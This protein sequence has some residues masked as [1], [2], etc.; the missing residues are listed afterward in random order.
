MRLLV[1]LTLLGLTAAQVSFESAT[2]LSE[3][4]LSDFLNKNSDKVPV[5][6][7]EGVTSAT[8]EQL[9]KL[10]D[11]VVPFRIKGNSDSSASILVY[12][13]GGEARAGE[14]KPF[15]EA[16]LV[17]TDVADFLLARMQ[18]K[19]IQIDNRSLQHY[20]GQYVVREKKKVFVLFEAPGKKSMA[21]RALCHQKEFEDA[22]FMIWS[23]DIEVLK[24][25]M[26]VNKLPSVIYFFMP[27]DQP[28]EDD[29]A[30]KGQGVGVRPMNAPVTFRNLNLF[31][32]IIL[33][34]KV[35]EAQKANQEKTE[36]RL[37]DT[38]V[39]IGDGKSEEP[40]LELKSCEK[41][42]CLLA[43]D[44]LLNKTD[45]EI[46]KTAQVLRDVQSKFSKRTI[47]IILLDAVCYQKAMIALDL[48]IDFLPAFAIYSSD[49]KARFPILAKFEVENIADFI[50]K[51]VS[52]RTKPIP[53]DS[54]IQLTDENCLQLNMLYDKKMSEY[55]KAKQEDD[56]SD[57]MEELRKEAAL[58]EKERQNSR[59]KKKKRDSDL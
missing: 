41:S 4:E 55:A 10:E 15:Q 50:R 12:P 28:N 7:N 44:R 22:I 35:E 27:E 3:G 46:E 39:I 57:I 2:Q 54:Q 20:I 58:K 40:D 1:F 34:G 13:L 29:E 9:R 43:F 5:R 32:K 36:V 18:D 26:E 53:L 42:L 37:D 47:K 25:L 19:F 31:V 49:K 51:A 56:D 6:L 8:I 24:K 59:S 23:D 16:G 17:M 30:K 21:F 11:L 45:E 33:S 38:I 48:Q 14:A 52:E